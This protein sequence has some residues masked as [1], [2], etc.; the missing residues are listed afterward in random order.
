MPDL[1]CP[2]S[3]PIVKQDFACQ[4]AQEII[5]R[6]GSEI[7]CQQSEVHGICSAWHAAIKA[8]AL[9]A[10]ELEDDLLSLPHNVLVKIQYGG[11]LG[12]QHLVSDSQDDTVADIATLV[13]EVSSQFKSP[14]A[15]PLDDV[16]LMRQAIED[17]CE[18]VDLNEW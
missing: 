4:H 14:E 15:I 10:M 9:Q 5:R 13:S 12:L 1:L 8:S 18:Q 2:F 16:E 17:G 3:A 11:L 6:G 7:A